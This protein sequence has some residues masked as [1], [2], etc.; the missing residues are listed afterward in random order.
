[1]Q[2]QVSQDF[3][4]ALIAGATAGG[5]WPT[6]PKLINAALV[7]AAVDIMAATYSA[8]Q[9]AVL[10]VNAWA[11]MGNAVDT[12]GRPVFPTVSPTN[13]VGSFDLTTPSGQVRGLAYTSTRPWPPTLCWSVSATPPSPMLGPVGTLSAD[14]PL[15]LGRDVAVYRFAAF[16]VVDAR[17]LIAVQRRTSTGGRERHVTARHVEGV[18]ERC[19]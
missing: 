13:P 5:A 15:K 9:V 6:D 2:L 17:G 8:P 18:L 10:G 1:M 16:G 14:V 12:E 4:A 11:Q 7:G 3:G 19:T